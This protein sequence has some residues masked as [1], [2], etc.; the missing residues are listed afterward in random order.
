MKTILRITAVLGAALLLA[1][2]VAS[3]CERCFGVAAET[4]VTQGISLAMLSLIT[5]TGLMLGGISLF[6]VHMNRRM[7]MFEPGHFA[8]NEFG[9]MV[10][11]EEDADNEPG[12]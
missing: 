9:E 11:R 12:Y 1:P 3:A 2:R 10:V 5:M 7:K 8:I 4:P 6:F